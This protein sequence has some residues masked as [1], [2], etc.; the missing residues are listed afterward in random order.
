VFYFFLLGV[1]ALGALVYLGLFLAHVPG[2]V[3]E[4]LGKFE[5]LPEKLNEWVKGETR[6]GRVR[7]ERYLFDDSVGQ[8]GKLTLQ[9]R[10]RDE[11]SQEIVE[12]LP[13]QVLPRRRIKES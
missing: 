12:V 1:A 7:E 8:G 3:E 13:E 11:A 4:R 9:V 2:A 6:D 5:P 10:F